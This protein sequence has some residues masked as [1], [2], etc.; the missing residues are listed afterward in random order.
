MMSEPRRKAKPGGSRTEVF[1]FRMDPRMKYLSEIAARKQRRSLANFIEWAVERA[2]D[3]TKI[4]M[5]ESVLSQSQ[6]LWALEPPDRLV[7]LSRN[8]PDLLTYEEQVIMR[9]IEEHFFEAEEGW[10]ITFLKDNEVN[11][12]LVRNCWNEINAMAAGE[13]DARQALNSAMQKW[14]EIPY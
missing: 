11:F 12:P 7:I 10:R 2:L 14:C 5:G 9:I 1:A 8:Y 4:G 13:L 3:E 6:R